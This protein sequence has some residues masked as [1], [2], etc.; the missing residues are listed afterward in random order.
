MHISFFHTVSS[1]R[2]ALNIVCTHRG[3][4][5]SREDGIW[6]EIKVTA[7]EKGII[8]FAMPWPE[9]I[10]MISPASKQT[11]KTEL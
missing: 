8:D 9:R 4:F 2:K 11:V 3:R 6:D 10:E 7:S 1:D 5:R